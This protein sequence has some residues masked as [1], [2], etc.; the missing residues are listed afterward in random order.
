MN[1]K[2][3][4]ISN[5]GLRT[6]LATVV[7]APWFQECVVYA[8]STMLEG[9]RFNLDH[10]IGAQ[11]FVETLKGM[12]QDEPEAVGFP[13]SGLVHNLDNTKKPADNQADKKE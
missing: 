1:A 10:L 3:L 6:Q 2:S 12:C 8:N 13:R 9:G 7:N 4:F 5:E 11:K